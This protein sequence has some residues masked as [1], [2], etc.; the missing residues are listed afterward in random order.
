[1]K[2]LPLHNQ[3]QKLNALKNVIATLF[4]I[5]GMVSASLGQ[6]DTGVSRI[7]GNFKV[8]TTTPFKLELALANAGYSNNWKQRGGILPI[9]TSEKFTVDSQ[10]KTVLFGYVSSRPDIWSPKTPQELLTANG[11][12]V[13]IEGVRYTMLF[14]QPGDAAEIRL[15]WKNQPENQILEV[16]MQPLHDTAVWLDRSDRFEK[17]DSVVFYL[18]NNTEDLNPTIF[19]SR[20]SIANNHSS[21]SPNGYV[22]RLKK[23]KY[24]TPS[25]DA[26]G[27]AAAFKGDT[28]YLMSDKELAK[29]DFVNDER[30]IYTTSD[31]LVSTKKI[32]LPQEMTLWKYLYRLDMKGFYKDKTDVGIIANNKFLFNVKHKNMLDISTVNWEP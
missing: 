21:H 13:T 1:M 17:N 6:Q 15:Q 26:S 12:E 16:V 29:V 28:F 14:C 18:E 5:L 8:G 3:S 27:M 23:V 10:E 31:T 22:Y 20:L 7:I 25:L 32:G 9:M 24:K 19:A 11:Y 4:I 30:I 2:G